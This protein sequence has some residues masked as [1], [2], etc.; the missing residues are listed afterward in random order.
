MYFNAFMEL[1]TERQLG[2]AEGPIPL[3]AIRG[4]A[5][6]EGI[7]R[8]GREYERLKVLVWALDNVYLVHRADAAKKAAK[9]K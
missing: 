2:Q 3:S 1:T 9:K 4:W 7:S 5:D 8:V 6:D